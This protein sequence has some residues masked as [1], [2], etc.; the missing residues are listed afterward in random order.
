MK[1]KM[2]QVELYKYHRH[3]VHGNSY[4]GICI[5]CVNATSKKAAKETALRELVGELASEYNFPIDMAHAPEY[6][7]IEARENCSTYRQIAD[8]AN[9]IINEHDIAQPH[10]IADVTLINENED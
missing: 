8:T 9:H 3:G 7:C 1:E 4:H 5:V 2:Y 10:I 6:E